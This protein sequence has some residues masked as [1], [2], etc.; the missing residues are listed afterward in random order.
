MSIR[1]NQRVVA[2]TADYTIS[3]AKGDMPGTIFTN[4]GAGANVTFT[5]PM[6]NR[7]V[8]GHWYDFVG[9]VAFALN[10]KTAVADTMIALNDNAADQVGLGTAG[11]QIGG[12]LHAVCDGTQW[13][14]YGTA[15]GAAPVVAT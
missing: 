3:T 8:M 14:V 12:V 5:L 1:L 2:K 7:A 10:V 9:L 11:M 6:P 13:I 15:V 4:R